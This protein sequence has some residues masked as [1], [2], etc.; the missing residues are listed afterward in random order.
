MNSI[1]FYVLFKIYFYLESVSTLETSCFFSLMSLTFQKIV[2][3]NHCKI[4]C[5]FAT[6][7]NISFILLP[8]ITIFSEMKN[9]CQLTVLCC[10]GVNGK[11]CVSFVCFFFLLFFVKEFENPVIHNSMHSHVF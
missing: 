3:I 8:R 10:K 7:Q 5:H 4:K 9:T 2:F 6:G 11:G 1:N